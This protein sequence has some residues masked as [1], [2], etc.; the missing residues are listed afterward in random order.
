MKTLCVKEN[1]ETESVPGSEYY[2]K[3]KNNRLILISVCAECGK[4]KSIEYRR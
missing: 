3:T 2:Q 1:E 4:K